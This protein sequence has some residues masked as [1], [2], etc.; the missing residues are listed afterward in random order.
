MCKCITCDEC[1]GS[2]IIW[3]AM[4]GTYLGSS[5]LDDLDDHETCENCRGTGIEDVCEEC[6]ILEMDIEQ[7]EEEHQR[8]INEV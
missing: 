8:K 7:E 4:D 2:G 6:Q 3:I 5:R 1:K